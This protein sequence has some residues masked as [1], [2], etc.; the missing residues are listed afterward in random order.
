VII[1]SVTTVTSGPGLRSAKSATE[2]MTSLGKFPADRSGRS[3]YG[4]NG[5]RQ[6]KQ[7]GRKFEY[8]SKN[9]CLCVF[10]FC[11]VLC[12]GRILGTG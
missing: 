7:W 12:A 2:F 10:L 1:S 6:L 8:H 3:V 9:G 4:M 11:V 5:L